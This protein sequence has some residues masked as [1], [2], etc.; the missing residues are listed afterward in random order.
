MHPVAPAHG[1]RRLRVVAKQQQAR[2]VRPAACQRPVALQQPGGPRDPLW[3][4]NNTV[5]K[6]T[7]LFNFLLCWVCGLYVRRTLYKRGRE[8]VPLRPRGG[9]KYVGLNVGTEQ[10]FVCVCVQPPGK[11]VADLS[12]QAKVDVYLWYGTSSDAVHML[13]GLPA[14]FSAA[15][16][17][18]VASCPPAALLCAG[19][20][21][22]DRPPPCFCLSPKSCLTT[23]EHEPVFSICVWHQM[24]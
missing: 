10:L 4:D 2:R 19:E 11:R 8:T 3:Q 6:G 9:Y 1:A 14:G 12:V 18:A 20:G 7:T 23:T 21:R 13:D 17:G 16:G 24:R 5:S 22:T 15:T